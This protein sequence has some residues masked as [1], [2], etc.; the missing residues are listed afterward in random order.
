VELGGG[1]DSAA[2][3]VDDVWLERTARRPDVEPWLRTET[4]L[5][6]WLAPRLPL[7]VPRP[8]VVREN[9][10][11]VRHRLVP[12]EP[13][14]GALPAHG[15]AVGEFL[16]ALHAVPA[17][18]AVALGVPGPDRT[19][20]LRAA[21]LHRFRTE[22]VAMLPPGVHAAAVALCDRLAAAPVTTLVHGD[23]NP[24]HLL[25]DGDRVT[26]VIDWSDARVADPAKD[27]AW[28]LH[29][30]PPGFA[31]AVADA[32]RP[33]PD[34]VARAAD[35]QRVGPFYAVAHGLD[36]GDRSLVAS[37]RREIV[38]GTATASGR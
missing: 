9:P 32:Y 35:W 31:A 14:T 19:A 33:S 5:L 25:V 13:A 1:W 36:T 23:L 16:R 38:D 26:G 17:G 7:P 12:G 8:S 24:E 4:R 20:A 29:G 2:V 18:D 3:L 28:A 27:L 30:A 37:G 34:E 11:V 15:T 6:P 21:A 22:I 10:L